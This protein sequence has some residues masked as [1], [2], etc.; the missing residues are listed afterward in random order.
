MMPFAGTLGG[1]LDKVRGALSASAQREL[2]ALMDQLEVT[3]VPALSAPPHVREA[4]EQAWFERQPVRIHYRS[5]NGEGSKRVVR[6]RNVVMERT[7]TFLNCDDLTKGEDRQF[8]L[9]RIERAE[10][11]PGYGAA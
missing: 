8:R 3:G 10:V 7:V 4:I 9:D 11:V 2:V 5:S 6:I 1:A